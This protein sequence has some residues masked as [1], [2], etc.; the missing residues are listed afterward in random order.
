MAYAN[1]RGQSSLDMVFGLLVLL[2]V[3]NSF[4]Y[5][6][7]R[8]E[9]TQ[10]EISIRQQIR[11]NVWLNDLFYVYGAFQFQDLHSYPPVNTSSGQIIQ[12]QLPY[13]INHYT[14]TTGTISFPTVRALGFANG[15]PCTSS[16]SHLSQFF[17]LSQV[18]VKAS[19]VGIPWDIDIN[20]YVGSRDGFDTNH[21]FAFDGC[22]GSLTVEAVPYP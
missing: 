3:L 19:D 10:K 2:I 11:D 15:V 8:F 6:W 21:T 4:T 1:G 20:N 18:N 5:V 12:T 13:L 17:T 7:D 22:G 14:R 9:E 16:L